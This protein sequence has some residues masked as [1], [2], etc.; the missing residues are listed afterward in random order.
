MRGP[1]GLGGTLGEIRLIRHPARF[2]EATAAG[3]D[4]VFDW[5]FL[6]PAFEGTKIQPMDLDAVIERNGHFLCF[7]TKGAG[8]PVPK[9][10]QITLNSLLASGAWTVIVLEGKSA[11]TLSACTFCPPRRS[12]LSGLYISPVHSNYV[13]AKTRAWLRWVNNGH[14]PADEQWLVEYDQEVMREH[15]ARATRNPMYGQVS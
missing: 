3:F 5:D 2:A 12:L 4:G 8:V 13:V 15:E 6:L 14:L 11:E 9:G 7:E 1:R 10:Q